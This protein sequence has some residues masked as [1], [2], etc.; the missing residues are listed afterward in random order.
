M[1]V[2]LD[3]KTRNILEVLGSYA[4]YDRGVRIHEVDQ[5]LLN[6]LYVSHTE[7]GWFPTDSGY[8]LCEQLLKGEK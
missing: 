8:D 6:N 4:H 2:K 5:W 3:Q 7:E 1:R